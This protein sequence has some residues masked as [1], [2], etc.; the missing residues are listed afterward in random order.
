MTD[1]STSEGWDQKTN[2]SE[3]TDDPIQATIRLEV[4]RGHAT[5]MIEQGIKDYSQWFPG[6]ENVVADSLS[7]DDD[8][9]D[10]TLTNLLLS[11]NIPQVPRNF[12]IVP[13]PNEISSWLTSTLQR[14]P[15]REQLREEHKR[16]KLG[17][18]NDGELGKTPLGSA[19][20]LSSTDSQ[21]PT[22][23]NCLERSPWLCEMDV[24][25]KPFSIPWLKAQS[26]IP[27]PMWHRP[28]G[29]TA[30]KIPQKMKT[31]KLADFYNAFI[32]AFETT[33]PTGNN[34]RRSL[35]VSS[36]S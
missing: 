22:S 14:L 17:R 11:L 19:T 18:G 5:R 31:A 4:A 27:F 12:H 7:R 34:K 15:V 32:E 2:F 13:L 26:A 25:L 36:E 3:L 24:S 29:T 35:S 30:N 20:T 33:T 16:T 8:L 23:I 9:S 1:S 28:S 6:R 10:K 21:Q